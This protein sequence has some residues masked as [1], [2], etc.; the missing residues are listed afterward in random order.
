MACGF[1]ETQPAFTSRMEKLPATKRNVRP[2]VPGN[3]P[4]PKNPA[5]TPTAPSASNPAHPNVAVRG[6]S[7]DGLQVDAMASTTRAPVDTTEVSAR[8][9]D[10]AP[11]AAYTPSESESTTA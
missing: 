1:M 7:H 11:M 8:T 5:S 3:V 10:D 4:P 2:T 9:S 6:P